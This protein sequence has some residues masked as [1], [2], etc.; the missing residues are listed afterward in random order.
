MTFDR[1]IRNLR[2]CAAGARWHRAV[3]FRASRRS[4]RG[5]EDQC[6]DTRVFVNGNDFTGMHEEH[7]VVM[8]LPEGLV[9][10]LPE[11]SGAPRFDPC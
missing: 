1:F 4:Y 9:T 11:L 6:S 7:A 5:T 10:R 8:R 2:T 3:Q